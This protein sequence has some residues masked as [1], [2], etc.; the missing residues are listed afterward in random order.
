MTKF[1][2]NKKKA[3]RLLYVCLQIFALLATVTL[4]FAAPATHSAVLSLTILHTSDEHSSILPA[5]LGDYIAS[6]PCPAIGG[7]ARLAT[8]ANQIRR[9]KAETPLLILS[10]GDFSG[11]TPFAWLSLSGLAPELELMHRIGYNA[12]SLG[13]HEFDYGSE[14]FANYCLRHQRRF[15][16]PQILA[17]NIVVPE[18]HPFNQVNYQTSSVI[19][20]RNSLKIGIFAILG[21]SAHRLSPSAKPLDFSDQLQAARRETANLQAAGAEVIIA[22]THAG[23]HEDIALAKSVEG[24]HLILGGHDHLAFEQ[25][26]II[27]NTLIMHSGSY[28][29][30]A[31]Q[32]D[33]EF[34]R[35][36]RRLHLLNQRTGAPILHHLTDRI[37][38]DPEI[39]AMAVG[40]LETLNTMVASLTEGQITSMLTPAAFSDRPLQKHAPLTETATGNFI[41]DA[42]RLE[43]AKVTGQRV[44]F[45][46]H[47]NGII[48]GDIHPSTIP[49]RAGQISTFDLITSCSLGSSQDGTPG[50]SIVS[51][52]LTGSEILRM[53]EVATLLPLLWNDIYFLQ[54]SG[55]RYH[56]DPARAIWLWLPIVNKPVPAYRSVILAER[57]TG[58]GRQNDQDFSEI[59]GGEQRLYHVATT[60][61]MASYLPIVGKK[62]PRLNL[63]LK[64]RDGQPTALD[65][66]IVCENTRELKLWE[67]AF[68][69]ARSFATN[70]EGLSVIPDQYQKTGGRII[71]VNAPSLWLWPAIISS[72]SIAAGVA[73][74]F[75][76]RRRQ[77]NPHESSE[78]KP[79]SV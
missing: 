31:G 24:I 50:Y 30:T 16:S 44:D 11:G 46:I 73:I 47:A 33:L 7:F 78:I 42:I 36:S 22:L 20:L 75:F 53:L 37:A 5:P 77:K 27:K 23:L 35:R 38:E 65:D 2:D 26:Q 1:F 48:R 15:D 25:P 59:T 12:V 70:Q 74:T 39:A 19:K 64:N 8:L 58:E 6:A 66:L 10:S 79:G 43:T 71:A 60:H 41:A 72:M 49:G 68:R 76:R 56:Y 21:K 4:T 52:Y 61:Y 55:L 17:S 63:V 51:F 13:N 67:V 29:Q 3:K 69:Y 32:L 57:F 28:L 40:C 62:L 54:V 18:Q 45:A 34:D 14:A 9:Q